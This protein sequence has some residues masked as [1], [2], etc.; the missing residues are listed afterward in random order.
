MMQAVRRVQALFFPPDP[1]GLRLLA[2][3]R[4]TLAGVLAFAVVLLLGQV[5]PLPIPDRILAFAIALFIGVTVRDAT[6]RG[7]LVTFLLAPLAAFAST[8]VTTLAA[9]VPLLDAAL[10]PAFMFVAAW[11][12]AR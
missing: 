8:T 3:L 7:R 10:V 11:G 1:G 12:N 9:V 6:P 4:A 5:L 2:A